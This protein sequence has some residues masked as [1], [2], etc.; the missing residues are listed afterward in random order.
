VILRKGDVLMT[1]GTTRSISDEQ[2]VTRSY[3]LMR[4]MV[5]MNRE[6][7][8]QAENEPEEGQSYFVFDGEHIEN[9][10]PIGR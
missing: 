10:K 5:K 1:T 8:E 3:T 6:G 2:G 9:L 7:D 4:L